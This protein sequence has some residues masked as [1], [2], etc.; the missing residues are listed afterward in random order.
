MI[1]VA[2][3]KVLQDRAFANDKIHFGIQFVEEIKVNKK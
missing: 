1:P 3:P 2:C